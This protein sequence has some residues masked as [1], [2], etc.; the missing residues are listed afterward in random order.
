MRLRRPGKQR[1]A[2][3]HVRR[4]LPPELQ[5]PRSSTGPRFLNPRAGALTVHH[6][7]REPEEGLLRSRQEAAVRE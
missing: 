5:L 7:D 3:A 2:R 4:A 6:S 1:A